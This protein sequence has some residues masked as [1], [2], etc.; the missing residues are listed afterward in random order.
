MVG[1]ARPP[2][3]ALPITPPAMLG[4][5]SV[6]LPLLVAVPGLLIPLYVIGRMYAL[7]SDER[8]GPGEKVFARGTMVAMLVLM[9]ISVYAALEIFGSLSALTASEPGP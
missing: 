3:G 2:H 8:R 5:L 6:L 1:G 4:S 7:L 9:G